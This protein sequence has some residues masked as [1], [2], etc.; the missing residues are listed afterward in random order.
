MGG[1]QK[2]S[3]F[4][5]REEHREVSKWLKKIEGK[6]KKQVKVTKLGGGSHAKRKGKSDSWGA[7]GV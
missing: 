5:T 4:I 7:S 2:G 3:M 6:L 1:K